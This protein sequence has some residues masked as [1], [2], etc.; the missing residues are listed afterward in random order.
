[1]TERAPFFYNNGSFW[2]NETETTTYH[3][4]L[5][6]NTTSESTAVG[7]ENS[8]ASLISSQS[9]STTSQLIPTESTT[10]SV[11]S[12]SLGYL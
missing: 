9:P 7:F 3:E 11:E 10:N 5:P 4:F 8:T 12:T 6:V 2:F 1:M